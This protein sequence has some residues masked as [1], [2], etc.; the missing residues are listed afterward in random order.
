MPSPLRV[1]I[2]APT[3]RILGG[4]AVQA[5][6]LVK[7]WDG[8]PDVRAWLVPI[9]PVPSGPLKRLLDVKF[10]R[11]LITQ[12]TYWPL[13]VRELR[14]A[15]VVHV[16]SAS[17]FSF[18]LAPL[19]AVL[20]A[21]LLG[22]PI[23]MNY[24]SG[25]APD[26]LAR[27]ATARR[28]LRG[29]DGN[30]VPS[31]FLQR[32]FGR[33][34]IDAKVIPNIVDADRFAFRLRKPLRPR[35]LS[36]RNFEPLY[37][38][39]CTLKAFELVQRRYPDAT[40]TL[41]GAGSEAEALRRLA[42]ERDLRNVRFVGSVPA[43]EM[44][45]HYAEADIYLQT[46]E[47]DNMPAS[48]LEAFASGCAVVS[49][50]AGGVPAILSDGEHGR[51]VPCGD[52]AA[53]AEAIIGLIEDPDQAERLTTRARESCEA[54]RW[55]CVRERWVSLYRSVIDAHGF[56]SVPRGRTGRV[57]RTGT[58]EWLAPPVR[59]AI[60]APTLRILGG[61]SVQAHRLLRGWEHDSQVQAWL[62][63]INP[64]PYGPLRVL[65][66]IKFARTAATQGTYWPLLVR[67]LRHAD[68]VHIFSASYFSFLLAPLPA[69]VVARLLRKP[70]VMNYRS[71]EAPD[72]LRRS[73]IARVALRSVAMNVVP[74][75]FLKSVFAQFRIDTEVIPDIVDLNRF[76]F[77]PRTP[78]RR[79]VLSTRNFE[80]L[81]NVACTL[82]AFA[83]V[84]AKYPD[85]T[86]T[87][88]GA[89]TQEGT[90]RRL[91]AGL[92]LQAVD[93]VGA[94]AP[95]DMWRYYAEADIYLQTPDIDNMPG[96]VLEAFA[97]GCA[98]VSTAAGGVPT[99]LADG[100]QGHL[101]PCGDHAAAAARVVQLIE[102]PE[103][104]DR[105]AARARESCEQYC[106]SVVR[107]M[108][109]S[110]YYRALGSTD[111]VPAPIRA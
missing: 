56:R 5:D 14:R 81:Y 38:V 54:Y 62:V 52:Y 87:V 46:P 42:A 44:W 88:V 68:V 26:H 41:V 86:L 101:V 19:P 59:V 11:T 36:T 100:V 84:Q 39:A 7:A 47:I 96:S 76:A 73:A 48:I 9:N 20:V 34:G 3:L 2:V 17:Y 51:L 23:V 27:S 85:A 107:A 91:A 6:R 110:A 30:V 63:P 64:A 29:V 102:N 21:R 32:V 69:L 97:S 50:D 74:S 18:F 105:L 1:A 57:D 72:H 70:V 24:R 80:P 103:L 89:G 66:R 79:R 75:A 82:R 35:V 94:V 93:F 61:H 58:G 40:L 13:L 65:R 95:D 99:I 22:R 60:V 10:V 98:V 77:R 25:E 31:T 49:S 106:W 28:V 33:F 90:L 78:R 12:L 104:A 37:N 111:V 8:D 109:V 71:G 16:F 108:W 45:R 15:D 43:D 92:G 67:E 55:S 83:I 4:Q 53:A